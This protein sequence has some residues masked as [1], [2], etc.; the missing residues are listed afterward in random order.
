MS[1]AVGQA[2]WAGDAGVVNPH[3]ALAVIYARQVLLKLLPNL[4]VHDVVSESAQRADDHVVAVLHDLFVWLQQVGDFAQ[5][6]I[7]VCRVPGRRGERVGRE[8]QRTAPK[9]EIP[10]FPPSSPPPTPPP[11][12]PAPQGKQLG[13]PLACTFC[14]Q[15]VCAFFFI[16]FFATK[17]S[18]PLR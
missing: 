7:D 17:F 13:F 10:L 2:P 16:F 9:T 1:P 18:P 14:A 8:T 6:H 11:Q 3:H 15:P 4:E 5:G 12:E